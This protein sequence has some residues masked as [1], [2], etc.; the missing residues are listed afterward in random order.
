MVFIFSEVKSDKITR[1]ELS[2][3]VSKSKSSNFGSKFNNF[4]KGIEVRNKW[5]PVFQ[6]VSVR[7]A[8]E[9]LLSEMSGRQ[10]GIYCFECY[11]PE[12]LSIQ[13][14]GF[15]KYGIQCIQDSAV[16]TC[17]TTFVYTEV[18]TP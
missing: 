18:S 13:I 15:W 12:F 3:F 2:D 5:W 6:M 11:S 8:K 14:A 4:E 16:L 1:S 9:Q 10:A 7:G 17:P